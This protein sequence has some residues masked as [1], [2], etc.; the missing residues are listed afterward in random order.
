MK[1]IFKI[2]KN[3]NKL[4]KQKT[5]CWN[6]ANICLKYILYM[7]IHDLNIKLLIVN[8]NYSRGVKVYIFYIDYVSMSKNNILY[9]L[10]CNKYYFLPGFFRNF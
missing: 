3:F 7:Y 10:L 8:A 9:R 2:G 4:R 5:S 1:H 6:V